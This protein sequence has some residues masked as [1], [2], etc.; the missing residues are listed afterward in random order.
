MDSPTIAKQAAAGAEDEVSAIAKRRN[1]GRDGRLQADLWVRR[2]VE[3]YLRISDPVDRKLAAT[4]ISANADAR[5]EYETALLESDRG[6][7]LLHRA[8][9]VGLAEVSSKRE[10]TGSVKEAGKPDSLQD[11]EKRVSSGSTGAQ[12]D[13]AIQESAESAPGSGDARHERSLRIEQASADAAPN[14][15][16]GAGSSSQTSRERINQFKE[17]PQTFGA[18]QARAAEAAI[19]VKVNG[20]DLTRAEKQTVLDRVHENIAKSVESERVR[21]VASSHDQRRSSGPKKTEQENES[22]LER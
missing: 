4:M 22:E 16:S 19:Q 17:R 13:K 11:G 14:E 9:N 1:E 8:R 10:P 2:D 6:A 5:S 21:P 18:D 15:S 12:S 3:D 7:V 20:T